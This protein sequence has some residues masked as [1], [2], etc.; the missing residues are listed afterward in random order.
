M[1]RTHSFDGRFGYQAPESQAYSC[2][3]A[4]L[5]HNSPALPYINCKNGL[6]LLGILE[7]NGEQPI[8]LVVNR[9]CSSG[10]G[11]VVGVW[12]PPHGKHGPRSNMGLRWG[13]ALIIWSWDLW[14][15]EITSLVSGQVQLIMLCFD[16]GQPLFAKS[17]IE[18]SMGVSR[19]CCR[20]LVWANNADFCMWAAWKRLIFGADS[21]Q[22]S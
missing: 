9:P 22:I 21:C 20:A 15:P 12:A 3:A 14:N 17:A 8:F 16:V 4:N 10:T 7:D 2:C 6:S 18:Q 13:Y 1:G 11:V 5:I 19:G